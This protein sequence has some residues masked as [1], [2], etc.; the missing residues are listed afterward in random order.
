MVWDAN[1]KG[2]PI[3]TNNITQ[4]G[5]LVA[6]VGKACVAVGA[7]PVLVHH[8]SKSAVLMRADKREPMQL[9]DLTG[10]GIGPVARQW[11]LLN[12]ASPYD[13]ETGR[14]SVWLN[15]GGSAGH[16]GLHLVAIDEGAYDPTRPLN[17]RTW[18]VEV[19]SGSK[20]IEAVNQAV[21]EAKTAKKEADLEEKQRSVLEAVKTRP[22][23]ALQRELADIAGINPSAIGPLLQALLQK[24]AI[25]RTKW[26]GDKESWRRWKPWPLCLPIARG[27]EHKVE[28]LRQGQ[29][30]EEVF[31]DWKGQAEAGKEPAT[32][33]TLA[34]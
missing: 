17:G 8:M 18:H 14:C 16:G 22:A 10:A 21:H 25:V 3:D 29:P 27:E 9:S 23:G 20:A 33:V 13:P 12:Y 32:S 30:L 31:P 6:D 28:F 2:R 26:P 11:L 24:Q 5:K 34:G 1:P 4:I 7:T 15:A 19:R